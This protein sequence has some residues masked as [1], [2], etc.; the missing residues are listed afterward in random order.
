[1]KQSATICSRCHVDV[2]ATGLQ[3]F[4]EVL[5][6]R[7]VLGDR[8]GDLQPAVHDELGTALAQ[9]EFHAVSGAHP[10]V[11]GLLARLAPVELRA[12]VRSRSP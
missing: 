12:E 3:Q 8:A 6:D 10:D 4:G 2:A 5:V 1:M 7:R 11:P 9:Q